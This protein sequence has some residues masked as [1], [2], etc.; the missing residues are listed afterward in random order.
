MAKKASAFDYK[1]WEG[2]ILTGVGATIQTTLL[3]MDELTTREMNS[4][5]RKEKVS[6]ELNK[7]AVILMDRVAEHML[8]NQ[9]G[10]GGR[11]IIFLWLPAMT[12]L[13][14]SKTQQLSPPYLARK[15]AKGLPAPSFFR[16]SGALAA[17]VRGVRLPEFSADSIRLRRS[18]E[19]ETWHK[20]PGVPG[21]YRAQKVVRNE[22]GRFAKSITVT[23]GWEVDIAVPHVLSDDVPRPENLLWWS[24]NDAVLLKLSNGTGGEGKTRR[25]YRPLLQPYL[26][27]YRT[28]VLPDT[29]RRFYQASRGK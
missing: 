4:R 22:R 8:G 18:E 5:K 9:I 27:W 29:I 11:R 14:Y 3:K 20:V 6:N 25:V 2:F 23:T 17:E 7:L 10:L 13:T 16:N 28:H 12:S 21:K 1:N 26:A 24:D 19:T 15:E